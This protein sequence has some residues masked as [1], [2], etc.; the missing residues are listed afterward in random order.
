MR[1]SIGIAIAGLG[2]EASD[3]DAGAE[4]DDADAV[5]RNADVAMYQAKLAG[6]GRYEIFAR[7]MHGAAIARLQ[8][9]TDLEA[10]LER[11]ELEMVYQPIVSIASGEIAGV[12]ALLRWHHAE[13]GTLLPSTFLVAAEETGL[14]VPIG[15]WGLDDACRQAAEWRRQGTW[16]TSDGAQRLM[17]VNL[18][19]SQ[20][21]D[22]HL[23]ENVR[24]ALDE[25]QL[26]PGSLVLE[27]TES[28]LLDDTEERI[29][30]LRA[31]KDLGVLLAIDDFGIGYSSFSYL[32]RLPVDI[33]KLDRSFVVSI[34]TR[35][36]DRIVAN[37]ILDLGRTL[38]LRVIA[39]GIETAAQ[40]DVLADLGCELGQGYLF[41]RAASAHEATR[42]IRD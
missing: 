20:L 18:S 26:A 9:R 29:A 25:H 19:V 38:G 6:K 15:R 2:P 23:V 8:L 28:A 31:L 3:V 32:R 27:I 24:R 37:A 16:Q 12:E 5:L 11:G 17:S 30:E 10:A 36:D 33:L 4:V 40:R 21:R 1:A 39:E 34:D 42:R 13:H 14:L 7:E 22:R 35:T 41:G